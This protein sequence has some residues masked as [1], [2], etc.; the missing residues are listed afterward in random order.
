MKKTIVL[1]T[2]ISLLL[3]AGCAAKPKTLVD[4]EAVGVVA[5]GRLLTVTDRQTGDNFDF[6]VVR[7][8]RSD[9][10]VE[11]IVI[12]T[13]TMLIRQTRHSVIIESGQK[14]YIITIDRGGHWNA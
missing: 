12:S 1:I 6:W 2:L 4:A 11:A 8:Q 10:D 14:V 13:P 9:A 5:C 7:V 3:V